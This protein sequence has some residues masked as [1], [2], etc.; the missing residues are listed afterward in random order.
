VSPLAF[1][2][3]AAETLTLTC[4][5]TV[6]APDGTTFNLTATSPAITVEKPTVSAWGINTGSGPQQ[7]IPSGLQVINNNDMTA[8]EIWGPMTISVPQ[9]F[10]G[11]MGCIAQIITADADN[12]TGTT[13]GGASVTWVDAVKNANGQ[14]VASQTPALDTALPFPFGYNL[15]ANGVMNLT[16][17]G[18]S[19]F[20]V[21][22]SGYSGDDPDLPMF[23]GGG[24]IWS[25]VL[26]NST[27]NT[28]VM[29]QPPGGVW[30]PLQMITWEY[31]W[32]AKPTP[33]GPYTNPADQSQW[34]TTLPSFLGGTPANTDTPP[35]WISV[36]ATPLYF[37]AVSQ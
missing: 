27:Y 9:P 32:T 15:G 1:Y 29:Y 36:E 25:K 8:T 33:G 28:Y 34:G 21:P 11:G 6:T 7:G 3:S 2:D 14:L 37:G 13:A 20:T 26:F 23:L 18:S 4:A 12:A 31:S 16:N 22:Q 35:T 24:I 19:A 10:T 17:T 30:V 5:V